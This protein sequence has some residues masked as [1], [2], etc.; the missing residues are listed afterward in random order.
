MLDLG[1]KGQRNRALAPRE[2]VGEAPV[3]DDDVCKRVRGQRDVGQALVVGRRG[4]AHFE[5]ANGF[6]TI[7][8]RAQT[9]L[10]SATFSTSMAC[11]PSTRPCE[12]P[13]SGRRSAV[14]RP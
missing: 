4:Q 14:S 3:G 8:D 11:E 9:R 1:G 13:V 10:P 12:V 7:A 6:T 5:Y 2:Q